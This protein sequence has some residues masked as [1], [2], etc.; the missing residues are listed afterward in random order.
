MQFLIFLAVGLAACV[1][2]TWY[3][4]RLSFGYTHKDVQHSAA[5]QEHFVCGNSLTP[6]ST[7][8]T[9]ASDSA[10]LLLWKDNKIMKT[11]SS[12]KQYLRYYTFLQQNYQSK[13][14][15][16]PL[17]SV[18][19]LQQKLSRNAMSPKWYDPTMT[20]KLFNIE[21]F[22]NATANTRA[23][24]APRAT[25]SGAACT[26]VDELS[27]NLLNT[28]L[29]AM[30]LRQKIQPE[31]FRHN[32]DL[33]IELKPTYVDNFYHYLHNP[34]FFLS[35]LRT[36]ILQFNIRSVHDSTLLTIIHSILSRVAVH[37]NAPH[38]LRHKPFFRQIVF[39]K[40][41][42][43]AQNIVSMEMLAHLTQE[44]Q[45]L[46]RNHS[47]IP[48][49]RPCTHKDEMLSSKP[50]T[51]VDKSIMRLKQQ[52]YQKH[53][54][55]LNKAV[56]RSLNSYLTHSFYKRLQYIPDL[57]NLS[58]SQKKVYESILR[59]IPPMEQ[60]QAQY[61]GVSMYEKNL[62]KSRDIHN[63]ELLAFYDKNIL[64][65]V[66]PLADDTSH[67]QGQTVTNSTHAHENEHT[68]NNYLFLQNS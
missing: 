20:P 63:K 32:G 8:V 55:V 25:F 11:F 24:S 33:S 39:P 40:W 6:L 52:W 56:M 61:S 5:D 13:M 26:A 15:Q 36:E 42:G 44:I 14:L 60:L 37:D 12:Y 49:G 62:L 67:I 10:P 66:P 68:Y 34:K 43:A 3:P 21:F 48:T 57:N 16:C 45:K 22:T 18:T 17:L 1:Y 4:W 64:M 23:Q 19:E 59:A 41:N 9:P 50:I 29:E 58:Q 35:I 28:I 46:V 38:A 30:R 7:H 47:Y 2:L 27:D 53:H 31:A 65:H 54:K 51:A